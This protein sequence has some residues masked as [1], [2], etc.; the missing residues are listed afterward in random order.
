MNSQEGLGSWRSRN[1]S[2]GSASLRWRTPTN[3][4]TLYRRIVASAPPPSR[5]PS[6]GLLDLPTDIIAMIL[7][8]CYRMDVSLTPLRHSCQAFNRRITEAPWFWRRILV[9]AS[10]APVDT[11]YSSTMTC[12]SPEM[13]DMCIARAGSSM[14]DATLVVGP[15]QTNY[16][17]PERRSKLLFERF[18]SH[19]ES[20]SQLYIT[21]RPRTTPKLVRGAFP[22]RSAKFPKLAS[23]VVR[24]DWSNPPVYTAFQP[25]FNRF[26]H[27]AVNLTSLTLENVSSDF[28]QAASDFVFWRRLRRIVVCGS[29]LPLDVTAFRK[30]EEL[31]HLSISGVRSARPESAFNLRGHG[32]PLS[33]CIPVG[34]IA[35]CTGTVR[36]RSLRVD[37]ITIACLQALDPRYLYRLVVG[38]ILHDL[39]DPV[40]THQSIDLSSLEILH[41][42]SLHPHMTGIKAP[43]LRTLC[44][45]MPDGSDTYAILSNV[46]H[47]AVRL[48][49]P[50][51]LS[52]DLVVSNELYEALFKSTP[53]VE[54][55]RIT[56]YDAPSDAFYG[57]LKSYNLLKELV[58]LQIELHLPPSPLYP[59]GISAVCEW[60]KSQRSN[61]QRL[62]MSGT[63]LDTGCGLR[64]E[65][66]AC[67][68]MHEIARM[69]RELGRT[70]RPVRCYF[71]LEKHGVT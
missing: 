71:E 1:P 29:D 22:A 4:T 45:G 53:D 56:L 26:G 50:K 63:T 12:V 8:M 43:N 21:I 48:W 47:D 36:V 15:L 62:L 31:E 37:A 6:L 19:S 39:R 61:L 57:A 55:L 13:L 38:S 27:T 41:A 49:G 11:K 44:L 18:M 35:H 10:E 70:F 32:G 20:F 28:V 17:S 25:L 34:Q 68:L 69:D 2:N 9:S 58:H 67:P 33:L 23:L 65:Q 7:D 64:Y 14:V 40:P 16:P 46:F 51:I 66:S 60:K 5:Q 42:R 24:F 3:D 52:L 59:D 30:C 54:T